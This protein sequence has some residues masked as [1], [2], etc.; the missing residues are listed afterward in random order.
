[1][2]L[3]EAFVAA[4]GLYAVAGV[5]FAAAFLMLGVRRVD[6]AAAGSTWGFYLMILPGVAALWPVLLMK[7]MRSR[8]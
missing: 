5:V 8:A 4:L 7:W 1:M 3:A 6:D 2:A